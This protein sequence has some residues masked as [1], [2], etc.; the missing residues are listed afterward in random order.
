M[1]EGRGHPSLTGEGELWAPA[2]RSCIEEKMLLHT[3]GVMSCRNARYGTAA[4]MDRK[5]YL[6]VRRHISGGKADGISSR[7]R[8]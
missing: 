5:V 6:E 7:I 4:E 2:R 3:V 1:L 8:R